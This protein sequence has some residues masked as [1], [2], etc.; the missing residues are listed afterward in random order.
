MIPVARNDHRLYRVLLAPV[1]SEKATMV[2]DKNNQV[3]FD[4]APDANKLEVKQA[5][6]RLFKVAVESVQILNRKGKVKRFGKFMGRRNHVKKA[7]VRLAAG[8][9]I[10]FEAET[11]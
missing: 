6:E 9:E 5:V 3:V 4:V 7:Y 2:S 8:Q 1:I 10:N 11:K